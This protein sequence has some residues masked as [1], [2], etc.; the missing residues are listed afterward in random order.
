MLKEPLV[1]IAIITYNRKDLLKKTLD[2]V[3][4]QTYK[5][6]EIIIADNHSEDGTEELC[7]EYAAKDSRIKYFRHDK[8]IGMTANSNFTTSKVTGKY[9]IGVC[10]DDWLELDYIEK[11][12][13]FLEKNPEYSI[14]FSLTQLYDIENNLISTSKVN[15]L[16]YNDHN[17]RIKKYIRVNIDSLYVGLFRTSIMKQMENLDGFFLKDRMSEDW[18]FMIKNLVAGK[19][20]VLNNVFYHKLHNGITKNIE[21]VTELWNVEGLNGDNFWDK[22]AESISGAILEDK[23]F[24]AYLP[25]EEIEKLAKV[26][27]DTALFHKKKRI[28]TYIKRHPLFLFRKDFYKVLKANI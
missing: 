2:S 13:D 8:N 26:V 5:N 24:T 23:F 17:K 15:K 11:C 12:V 21:A 25:T 1:S 7:R 10:D 3:I 4:N 9:W 27:Y 20:K 18:V 16:D 19:G 28:L 14:V 22:L 6:L